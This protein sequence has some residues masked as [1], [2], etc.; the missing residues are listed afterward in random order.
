VVLTVQATE[1]AAC[2]G[3]GETCGAGM[4]VVERL[5]LDGIDGECTRLAIDLADKH[6]TT[7]PST[8]TDTRLAIGYAAMMRT[9]QTLYSSI[10][11][12][13]IIST[14]HQKT[15]AS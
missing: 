11:Q 2:T 4:E 10:I 15:M 6:A 8:A 7:I 13:L 9:E 12:T 1:I 14:F 3:D 5:L